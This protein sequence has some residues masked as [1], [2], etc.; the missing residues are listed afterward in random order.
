MSH[1]YDGSLSG[2]DYGFFYQYTRFLDYIHNNQDLKPFN[3]RKVASDLSLSEDQVLFFF[4]QLKISFKIFLDSQQKLQEKIINKMNT[5]YFQSLKQ[6]EHIEISESD[7]NTFADFHY[8]SSI[9][10]WT[11]NIIEKHPDIQ[12]LYDSYPALFEEI[13]NNKWIASESG[14]YFSNE[15]K[16][17]AM[18]N[19]VPDILEFNNLKLKVKNEK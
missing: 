17:F 19:Q 6:D 2:G 15:W 10:A 1:N 5:I 12:S 14:A 8:L 18:L 11:K 3:F 16:N 4:Q 13:N 9:K 7:M